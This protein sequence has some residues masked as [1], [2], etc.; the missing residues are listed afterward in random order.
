MKKLVAIAFICTMIS[1]I[2]F[3]A[4]RTH[5]CPSCVAD[6][7]WTGKAASVWGKLTY[8]MKCP[9]DHISWEVDE[10]DNSKYRSYNKNVCQYDGY[11]MSFTGKTE[12]NG[13]K[14]FKQYQC[15][16]GHIEWR[17]K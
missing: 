1:S 16:E 3:A 2:V 15:A 10:R 5:R 4:P 9:F 14:S 6:M 8:E 17:T 13:R 7:K 12:I 11:S